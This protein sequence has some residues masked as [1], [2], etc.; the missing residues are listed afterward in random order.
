MTKHLIELRLPA[1]WKHLLMIRFYSGIT[2]KNEY[3]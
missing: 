3:V 1:E 2:Y